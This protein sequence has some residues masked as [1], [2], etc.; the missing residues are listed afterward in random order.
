MTLTTKPLGAPF[1]VGGV[2][3]PEEGFGRVG[4]HREQAD[5]VD[6]DQVRADQLGDGL[7]D[8][9]VGAVAA[10]QLGERLERVPGDGLA[11]VDRLVC[12]RFDEVALAGPA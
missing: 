6:Q 2:D 11:F 1:L 7:V 4:G 5:V 3:D 9:V 12:E 10:E 8:A